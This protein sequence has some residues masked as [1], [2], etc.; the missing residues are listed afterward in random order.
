[1]VFV[2]AVVLLAS[3]QKPAFTFVNHG[4]A[5][6]AFEKRMTTEMLVARAKVERFFGKPFKNPVVF[7]LFPSRASL[8]EFFEKRWKAP[9][10]ERWMVAAG[11]A[12]RV[13]ML[14]PQAWKT[15]ADE[16]DAANLAHVKGIV[17]HELVHSYHAQHAPSPEFDGMDELGWFIEGLATYASGQLET[18]HKGKDR[19][20]IESGKA[21]TRLAD[22]WTGRF[23]YAVSG[24]IVRYVDRRY[25]RKTLIRLLKAKDTGQ[26]LK[27][28]G[29]TERRLLDGWSRSVTSHGDGRPVKRFTGKTR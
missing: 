2:A 5:D 21:P 1:M 20:A 27:M 24:S 9:K 8:D 13:V 7:E 23:R 16:H 3:W 11:V 4:S 28:L 14:S 15:D 26:A 25:G 10:T 12:D 22:A 29:T 17:A 18:D 19:Q 6:P